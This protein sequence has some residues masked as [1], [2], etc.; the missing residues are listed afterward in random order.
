[1][2]SKKFDDLTHKDGE[3]EDFYK[4]TFTK[5]R[6]GTELIKWELDVHQETFK[7]IVGTTDPKWVTIKKIDGKWLKQDG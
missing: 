4:L 5:F 1:M 3:P 6:S 7:K 2:G